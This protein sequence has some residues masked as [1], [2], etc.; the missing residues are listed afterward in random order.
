MRYTPEIIVKEGM[1]FSIP[2]YQ[3][4]FEW[5][6]ENVLQLLTDLQKAYSLNSA[7]DY[8]VGMLTSTVAE[9]ENQLV[10]GQQRFTVMTLIGCVLQSYESQWHDFLLYNHKTRLYFESRKS[11]N[12]YLQHLIQQDFQFAGELVNVKMKAAVQAI[13]EFMHRMPEAERSQYSLYV[14]Q[15]LSFFIA[16]LPQNYR[17]QDLN[18]YFERMNSGGK[19][20]EQH[21]ILKV[22][23]LSKLDGD[24]SLHMQLW[25]KIADVDTLLIRRRKDEKEI[26]LK[27]RKTRALFISMDN[28]ENE[29]Y[30]F[31]GLRNVKSDSADDEFEIIH[32][33]ASTQKPKSD[34]HYN[35]GSRCVLR[36]PNLL[37]QVLYYYL[38]K[39]KIEILQRIDDFFNQNNLLETFQKYLPFE[40]ENVDVNAL[41]QF[42]D[43]LIHCRVI[44]DLC[45]VRTLEYGYSLDM[46]C[47]EEDP[48]LK[49]LLMFESFLYVSSS[50]Y[51]NY[52][53]FGWLMDFMDSSTIIPQPNILFEHLRRK[54]DA[55]NPLLPYEK[56]Y[57]GSEIRY[58][59]WRLDFYLWQ[60]RNELFSLD[61]EQE[62]LKVANNYVF[63]RSRSIEHIAPQQPKTESIIKW[64]ED[65][66]D[67]VALRNSFGNLAMISQ[68]MN[69]ALS[70]SS[71]EEKRAHVESYFK[72]VTGSIE[73]L[74]LLMVYRDYKDGWDKT[75][76]PVHGQQMYDYLQKAVSLE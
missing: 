15:H 20:L 36:F 9:N 11:D 34:I 3:R 74:K 1:E 8:Y 72:S 46:A 42:F 62:Y 47:S 18:K 45:F 33:S 53:W 66:V 25:N 41:R 13:T 61:D 39:N 64:N 26:D 63:T 38:S 32:V 27:S 40:G 65:D 31:N 14:F 16:E 43:L 76:I 49:E 75:S 51:T 56:L 57:F 60:H 70:N 48:R 71:Y 58:W 24:I 28:I 23:I 12:I 37:L 21:E 69:S 29:L 59:F 54:C 10:D 4:L 6:P 19:N 52:R 7:E 22:K 17:A 67:D 50:N 2:I 68:S 5:N 30:V 44:I 35:N 73:S 55:A